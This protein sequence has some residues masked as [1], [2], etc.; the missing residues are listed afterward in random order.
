MI[1][2]DR[3]RIRLKHKRR[4][5]K[6]M[7]GVH[8]R[9]R[10]CIFRSS[11]HI[12]AQIIDDLEGRTLVSAS[13]L[14]RELRDVPKVDGKAAKASEVGKLVAKRALVKGIKKVVFDRG[15]FLY[16]GRVKALANGARE[17]GLEF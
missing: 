12:Y 15:G 11:R 17:T 14:D 2:N 5:R 6:K 10:L 13:T 8:E 9:P 3:K 4:I 1:S 16:H 7:F